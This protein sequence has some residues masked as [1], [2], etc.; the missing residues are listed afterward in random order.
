MTTERLGLED[1]AAPWWGEA[2]LALS[3]L[4]PVFAAIIASSGSAALSSRG[5]PFTT[6][7]RSIVGQQISVKAAQSVWDRVLLAA[8]AETTPARILALGPDAL[9]AC[10]LSAR[11]VEY[12][13][14]LA[15]HFERGELQP[16]RWPELD[17]E[18]VIEQLVQVRGI[19]RWTA[20][21]FLIFNLLR[22]DVLPLDDI[23]L[24]KGIGVHWHGGITPTRGQARERAQAW[25]PWRT[26]AT[27]YLWRSLDPVPVAY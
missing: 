12:L 9:R 26:A 21:M 7:A 17:D 5:D 14:D 23:G 18:A 22:P 16:E 10:G 1:A 2:Q 8:A 3:A 24:L 4:D 6:L 20:E 15:V 19:G 13:S 27:W 25:A 11:K